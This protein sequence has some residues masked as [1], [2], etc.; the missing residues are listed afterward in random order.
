M[1]TFLLYVCAKKM[2]VDSGLRVFEMNRLLR[3]LRGSRREKGQEN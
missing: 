3:K 2:E 1:F